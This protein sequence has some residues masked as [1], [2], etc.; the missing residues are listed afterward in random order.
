VIGASWHRKRHHFDRC[1]VERHKRDSGKKSA[2]PS[3]KTLL[4]LLATPS[5]PNTVIIGLSK[6]RCMVAVQQ[7]LYVYLATRHFLLRNP[8]FVQQ[9]SFNI[10]RSTFSM[11]LCRSNTSYEGLKGNFNIFTYDLQAKPAHCI[12]PIKVSCRWCGS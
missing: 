10:S 4:S 7:V 12:I 3:R 6:P 11:E 9:V 8:L 1:C 5:P 2:T